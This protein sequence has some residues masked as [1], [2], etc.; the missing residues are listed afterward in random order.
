MKIEFSS[1]FQKAYKKFIRNRP[2]VAIVIL[3]KMLL[4]SQEPNA[5]SLALHKLKGRLEGVFAFSIE[6][7]L[8]IIVDLEDPTR[9][10]FVN[11]GTHDEV[12]NP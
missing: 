8:R 11:I 2:D 10:L 6:D 12:Y 1:K 5:P 9:A 4:F 3:N 7:D